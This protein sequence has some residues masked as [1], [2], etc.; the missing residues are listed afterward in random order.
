MSYDERKAIIKEIEKARK[1][2]IVTYFTSDRRTQP[3]GF[4]LPAITT[5]LASE[6]QIYLYEQLKVLGRNDNLDLFLYTRGGQ[7]DSVWPLVSIFREFIKEKFSVLIPFRAHSAGTLVSLG[8]D[9]IVMGDGGELSP[10]DPTTGNQFN[11]LDEISKK[12]RKGI[13]VED[14]TSFIDLAKDPK[15]V[16]LEKPEHILEVFLKLA[17]KINPIALGNVNRAHTQIRLLATKL[18]QYHFNDKDSKINNIVDQL[19][20]NLYSHT[21]TIN[22]KEAQEIL[23]EDFVIFASDDEQKLLW[24]LYE[25]YEEILQ[26]RETFCMDKIL[27]SNKQEHDLNIYGAFIET[28]EKSYIFQSQCKL[29]LSSKIPQGVNVQIPQGQPMPLIPGLS[30][31]CDIK[32]ISLGWKLNEKGV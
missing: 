15:K 20:K 12:V 27:I 21:H 14:V 5:R 29:R 28:T 4:P 18:L 31:N 17:E 11:P 24:S 2:K 6:S 7:T 8:A 30:V 19:S 10:I 9:N 25:E 16:G 13:S 3:E 22:R 1:S 23:G 26:L 32:T